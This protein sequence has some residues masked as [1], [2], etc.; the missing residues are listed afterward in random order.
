MDNFGHKLFSRQG[1]TGII[2]YIIVVI[3]KAIA[4]V[5]GSAIAFP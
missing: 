3:R 2:L 1:L 5:Q 4:P